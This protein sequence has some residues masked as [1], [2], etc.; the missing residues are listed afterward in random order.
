MA[1]GVHVHGGQGVDLLGNAHDA[2]FGADARSR[3]G[4]EHDGRE[5]RP[6]LAHQRQGHGHAQHALGTEFDQGAVSLKAEHHAREKGHQ[7]DDAERFEAD[8]MNVAENFGHEPRSLRRRRRP[9]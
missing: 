6:Q 2:D 5:H 7:Y 4:D 3:P 8:E 1:D 9:L